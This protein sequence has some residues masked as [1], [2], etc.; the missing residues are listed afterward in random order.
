M[1]RTPAY[2]RIPC[3]D[4]LRSP[5]FRVFRTFPRKY[6]SGVESDDTARRRL[7]TQRHRC[8]KWAFISMTVRWSEVYYENTPPDSRA[9]AGPHVAR[10]VSIRLFCRQPT[11]RVAQGTA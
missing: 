3:F 11:P 9:Q 4:P 2:S 5:V 6:A 10:C 1:C 7:T 8:E